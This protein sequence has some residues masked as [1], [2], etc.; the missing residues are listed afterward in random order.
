MKL[1]PRHWLAERLGLFTPESKPEPVRPAFD[2][3]MPSAACPTCG[4]ARA[5][6]DAGLVCLACEPAR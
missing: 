5:L 1:P 3:E 6:T 4:A 2:P